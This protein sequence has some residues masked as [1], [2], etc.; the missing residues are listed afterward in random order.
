[1]CALCALCAVSAVSATSGSVPSVCRRCAAAVPPAPRAG[2]RGGR[3]RGVCGAG[4][5]PSDPGPG[6]AAS[7]GLRRSGAG[8]RGYHPIVPGGL[9]RG[10]A[11]RRHC[12]RI[13]PRARQA[14]DSGGGSASHATSLVLLRSPSL[15]LDPPAVR[16]PHPSGDTYDA[17]F[18]ADRSQSR[19]R[20]PH[21]PGRRRARLRPVFYGTV[22]AESGYGLGLDPLGIVL[23]MLPYLLA[24]AAGALVGPP[25]AA[26]ITDRGRLVTG[27]VLMAAG[28]ALSAVTHT[29]A[30]AFAAV[31][32]VAGLG[33][34]LLQHSTR[35]LAV[36]AVPRD[37]TS[38]GSGI[39]ELLI[40]VGGSLG[41][42]VVLGVSAAHTR[43]GATLPDLG[44]YTT[45]WIL[46]SAVCAAGALFALL[47]RPVPEESR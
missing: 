42:A 24:I 38:V 15:P 27:C 30:A 31:N 23:A 47:H 29:S 6:S 5:Q 11:G 2:G 36:E 14:F 32:A 26:R 19:F 45:A 16:G 34:G 44:A 9:V 12:V 8:G 41:A 22:R 46:C 21:H 3:L 25:V 28:Y 37:R 18:R 35:T 13:R 43:P 7:A 33:I 20:R 17:P 40:S 1:M 39:N 10:A 4:R